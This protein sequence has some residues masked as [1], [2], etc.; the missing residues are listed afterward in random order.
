MFDFDVDED[1]S[2]DRF[3]VDTEAWQDE[4]AGKLRQYACW[5][6]HNLVAHPLIGLLP[7]RPLF[8]L[9]DWTSH[10]MHPVPVKHRCEGRT[11][12]DPIMDSINS[13]AK[14]WVLP[15]DQQIPWNYCPRCGALLKST[16]D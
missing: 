10:H 1:G 13:R 3:A 2:E 6:F 12:C 11:W 4:P 8:Q 14:N 7:F 5:L 15:A 9:H 16:P